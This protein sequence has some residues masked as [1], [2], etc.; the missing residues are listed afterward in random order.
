MRRF[1]TGPGKR[2][3]WIDPSGEAGSRARC[4]RHVQVAPKAKH[5]YLAPGVPKMEE[6]LT[7]TPARGSEKAMSDQPAT[8]RR[9]ALSIPV[10]IA[11]AFLLVTLAST[12]LGIV[13]G[14]LLKS[15][16]DSSLFG[17]RM[18][19][20]GLAGTLGFIVLAALILVPHLPKLTLLPAVLALLWQLA[21][22]PGVSWSI[23]DP[24]SIVPLEAVS[25]AA[26]I[27]GMVINRLT[28]GTLLIRTA[29]LPYHE[30]LAL[31][32][33]IAAPIAALV[34]IIVPVVAVITA[35]PVMIEQQT[36]G[37][38]KLGPEGLEVR[39]TIM[40]KGTS[41]VHLVGMVH[42]GEPEFYRDLYRSIPPQALVLAEGVTDRQGVMKTSPNYENAARGL[43]LES[44]DEFQQ[45]LRTSNRLD[46]PPPAEGAPAPAVDP[47]KPFV[48]FAD[49][50]ISDLTP[51]TRKFIEAV[52]GVFQSASFD[53]AL[54]KY[55][56]VTQTFTQGEMMKA[57]D[58]LIIARNR[59]ALENFDKHEPRFS[60]IYLPWGAGHMPDFEKQLK[61]RG[62][63]VKSSATRQIAR[64]GTILEAMQSM[65]QPSAASPAVQPA[66]PAPAPAPAN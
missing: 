57:M 27:L 28:Y 41:E 6:G 5:V 29:D 62:Y 64:Y 38:L 45:L 36:G 18:Q 8:G 61:A 19:L 16:L 1:C 65:A 2:R 54:Q 63:V 37:Y 66:N 14:L 52:G 50:D 53:E 60:V 44:Q 25:L 10:F 42:I 13:D 56:T 48:V 43:G 58:E 40:V 15:T 49:M 55:M 7:S 31:R 35:I 47:A 34:L 23:S 12:T 46:L 30:R 22:A 21:G 26:V 39:Q 3:L 20:S 4:I 32:T 59:K 24:S 9:I 11:N 51:E 17:L 33:L